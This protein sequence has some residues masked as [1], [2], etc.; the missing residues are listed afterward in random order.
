MF[1]ALDPNGVQIY[2][3]NVLMS[4]GPGF[5]IICSDLIFEQERKLV[6]KSL[7]SNNLKI[8]DIELSM[9]TNVGTT[10]VYDFR[11]TEQLKN[12]CKKI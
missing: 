2:H 11:N 9:S 5:A 8:I 1:N 4:I 7:R 10:H 12:F 3:T 6:H